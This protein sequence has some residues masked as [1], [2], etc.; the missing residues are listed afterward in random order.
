MIAGIASGSRQQNASTRWQARKLYDALR[1]D[2]EFMRFTAEDAAEEHCQAGASL[3]SNQRIFDW[4]DKT[5][6]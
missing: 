6:S 1:S 5:F 3:L 2:K 4:L